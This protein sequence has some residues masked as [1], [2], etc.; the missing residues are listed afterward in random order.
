M[1]LF[2]NEHLVYPQTVDVS[3]GRLRVRRKLGLPDPA[4]ML[5]CDG[6]DYQEDD[7]DQ[8]SRMILKCEANATERRHSAQ[9]AFVSH[10]R[11]KPRPSHHMT[12]VRTLA[13]LASEDSMDKRSAQSVRTVQGKCG[14]QSEQTYLRFPECE[15]IDMEPRRDASKKAL[16]DRVKLPIPD[17]AS[18]GDGRRGRHQTSDLF[19]ASPGVFDGGKFALAA[20]FSQ[21]TYRSFDED[22]GT[23]D[24]LILREQ[25]EMSRTED[26]RSFI[27]ESRR[28]AVLSRDS[29]EA[30]MG[31]RKLICMA[32]RRRLSGLP[33]D[34]NNDSSD[35]ISVSDAHSDIV[36]SM[37]VTEM[38]LAF[39]MMLHKRLGRQTT[40]RSLAHSGG[41]RSEA[42]IMAQVVR[43]V[44]E[45]F[46]KMMTWHSVDPQGSPSFQDVVAEDFNPHNDTSDNCTI[47][48]NDIM[49][50]A[51]C[52]L[53]ASPNNLQPTGCM[54]LV[55]VDMRLMD[56]V[57][58]YMAS[59]FP[60]EQQP[61]R[62]VDEV[63]PMKEK[64]P[65]L[66]TLSRT[67]REK[68]MLIQCAYRR[69]L[70]A[71]RFEAVREERRSQGRRSAAVFL[72]IK[73]FHALER[74]RR[75]ISRQMECKIIIVGFLRYAEAKRKFATEFR[76]RAL[77]KIFSSLHSIHHRQGADRGEQAHDTVQDGVGSEWKLRIGTIQRAIRAKSARGALAEAKTRRSERIGMQLVRFLVARSTRQ[78][79]EQGCVPQ[80]L[81]RKATLIQSNFRVFLSRKKLILVKSV[82]FYELHEEARV[83]AARR[84]QGAHICF[85][86][87]KR[88]EQELKLKSLLAS[89]WMQ[90]RVTSCVK[91][92]VAMRGFL[93]R[94][95]LLLRMKVAEIQEVVKQRMEL[96]M[97]AVAIQQHWR[98]WQ[99]KRQ[100]DE[101]LLLAFP[102]DSH[103]REDRGALR[104]QRQWRGH[105]VREK[106]RA[107]WRQL[108]SVR[109][110]RA[111][112]GHMARSRMRWLRVILP[113]QQFLQEHSL[114]S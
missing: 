58:G 1:D 32:A 108:A 39:A 114:T 48:S 113:A 92:Q 8:F 55:P 35:L 93:A 10:A 38:M 19:I 16:A 15:S 67:R 27:I 72:Q 75:L 103:T 49:M 26:G 44:L 60:P 98:R 53:D 30:A 36:K 81:G 71:G 34:R 78:A 77:F 69:H 37:H 17:V 56:S 2:H 18:F 62:K 68:C 11:A 96:S 13:Q 43:R 90:Q 47:L 54:R 7:F 100:E 6:T 20:D 33:E 50:Q 21:V 95:D 41:L 65:V 84:I 82:R 107:M 111:F 28:T 109:I 46:Q 70:A 87:R 66:M 51:G 102:Q 57:D 42:E 5:E 9:A 88:V 22:N 29:L 14:K 40:L 52:Q 45:E 80:L 101:N 79:Y 31:I 25:T 97:S 94:K 23:E 59:E 76:E 99:A 3:R 73:V 89:D 61:M 74:R 86:A 12:A 106:V 63:E 85:L 4:V 110:Q 104:I 83:H 112:R 24:E 64:K 105:S 91:L